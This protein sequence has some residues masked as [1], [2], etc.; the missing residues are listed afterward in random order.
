[1]NDCKDEGPEGAEE[2]P[3]EEARDYNA[4]VNCSRMC[5]Q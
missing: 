1:M 5:V 4:L 3:A 2:I